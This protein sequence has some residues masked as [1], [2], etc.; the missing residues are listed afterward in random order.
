[1]R[2]EDVRCS[3]ASRTWPQARRPRGPLATLDVV[4]DDRSR[5]LIAVV[6]YHLAGDRVAR[7]PEGGY[8]V[9]APYRM[10][11]DERVRGRRSSP[12]ARGRPRTSLSRSTACSWSAVATSTP[13]ATAVDQ[14][15]PLRDRARSRRFRDNPAP[16]GGPT[17]DADPLHLPGDASD[18]RRVRGNAPPPP[19]R[20]AEPDRA[21]RPDRRH[22]DHARSDAGAGKPALSRDEG[23]R[24]LVL[25]SSPSGRGS[26]WRWPGRHR[27]QPRW[28]DR[29]D[30]ATTPDPDARGS[31]WM[32]GVQWHPEETA[33]RDPEQQALFD[34]LVRLAREQPASAPVDAT[35]RVTRPA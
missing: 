24:A 15:A 12:Q 23:E 21:R 29:V 11:S 32:L 20:P 33:D 8:G 31:T 14:R 10:P 9:P 4:T 26:S 34:G 27:A 5:P 28:A 16:G 17:R 6:A 30:R 3:S 25:V 19:P 1:M 22:P 18:E 2:A 13:R 7:W 35:S